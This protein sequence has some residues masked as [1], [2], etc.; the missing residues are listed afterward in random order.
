M[1]TASELEP[2]QEFDPGPEPGER[3]TDPAGRVYIF[4]E[5]QGWEPAPDMEPEAS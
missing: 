4:T 5:R 2:W 3:G 1:K